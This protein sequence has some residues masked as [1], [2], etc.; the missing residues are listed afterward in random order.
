MVELSTFLG[1]DVP[2]PREILEVIRPQLHVALCCGPALAVGIPRGDENQ[3]DAG[4]QAAMDAVFDAL[5]ANAV[6]SIKSW[7]SDVDKVFDGE[8]MLNFVTMAIEECFG[9]CDDPVSDAVIEV[10]A[11]DAETDVAIRTLHGAIAP[12]SGYPALLP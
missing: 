2:T 6:G 3:A 9:W 1:R 11:L 12:F 5:V 8:K 4:D 10:V 7:A